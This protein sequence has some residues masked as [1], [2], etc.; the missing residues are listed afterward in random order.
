MGRQAF[1]ILIV[2]AGPAGISTWL[3][4]HQSA[5]V[6]A[7]RTL[8]VDKAVFPRAK[9]CGGGLWPWGGDVLKRLNLVLDP[10]DLLLSDVVFR[11][12]DEHWRFHN[13]QP[14]RMIERTAFDFAL[15]KAARE[16]GMTFHEDEPFIGVRPA[17]DGLVVET[18]R[19]RYRIKA[20]VG[21]DGSL[22]RVR[23]CMLPAHPSW[24]APALQ[25]T[26]PVDPRHDTEF[27]RQRMLIDFS[28]VDAGLQGYVWHFPGLRNGS[29]V[30]HHG[31]VDFRRGRERPR[32]RLPSILK[33]A[34]HDRKQDIRPERLAA[35]PIRCYAP[36]TPI[37]GPS[38]LLVGDA[39][40]IEPALG[41][42]IH[43]ALAYGEL[44]AR[45]LVQA[46][47]QGDF[48]FRYYQE[49]LEAHSL[50]QQIRDFTA[51]AH[52]LYSGSGNPLNAVRDFFTDRLIRMTL[53]TLMPRR[54]PFET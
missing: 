50:G 9:L 19:C 17:G 54:T 45:E 26:A 10:P 46:F 51:L 28:P 14:F 15:V 36:D 39:A 24:L 21:A 12:R 7:E 49:A 27:D 52:N 31:V 1:D 29:A 3:H 43:M 11:Y 20:L 48:S 22:S 8:L 44:A 16:R 42:G 23:R 25:V 47:Q 2:G 37:A 6:L 33:R 32:S 13:V 38:V 41:G 18:G 4:L 34:L 30:T 53:A 40:G 5:P 35:H